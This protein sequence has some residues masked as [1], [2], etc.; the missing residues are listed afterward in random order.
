MPQPVSLPLTPPSAVAGDIYAASGEQ[1][2]SFRAQPV[3]SPGGS[4]AGG[5][6]NGIAMR[7]AMGARAE[8]DALR[9][10]IYDGCMVRQG[11][12]RSDNERVGARLLIALGKVQIS[13]RSRSQRA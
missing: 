6:A 3:A 12:T 10:E 13:A 4:F 8:A 5:F 7:Q 9:A 2:G 1:V 11:W